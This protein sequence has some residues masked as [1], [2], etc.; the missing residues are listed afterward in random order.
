MRVVGELA[1]VGMR[2]GELTLS[3][4]SC[5]IQETGPHTLWYL[6]ISQSKDIRVED[7]DLPLF[8]QVVVWTRERHPLPP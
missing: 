8:S 5:S 4:A 2:A 1:L 6:L 7:V 3:L